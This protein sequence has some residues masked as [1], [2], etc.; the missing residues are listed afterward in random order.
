TLFDILNGAGFISGEGNVGQIA[1]DGDMVRGVFGDLSDSSLVTLL[2]SSL[3]VPMIENSEGDL[4]LIITVPDDIDWSNEITALGEVFAEVVDSGATINDVTEGDPAVL[5]NTLSAINVNTILSSEL[6]TTALINVLSQP[7]ILS[8]DF[9]VIPDNVTWRDTY[10][11]L[12]NLVSEGE[13]RH[14]LVAIQ[15]LSGVLA[16]FDLTNLGLDFVSGLTDDV[17]NDLFDSQV[18]VATVSDLLLSGSLPLDIPDSV[19]DSNG[20]ITK[21][22]I[23]NLSLAVKLIVQTTDGTTDL[24]ITKLFNLSDTDIDTLLS[25]EI[26]NVT[27]GKMVSEMAG[28]PLVVPSTVLANISVNQGT[29]VDV[30]TKDEIKAVI[31][32]LQA[33]GITSFDN[34]AFDASILSSL[35]VVPAAAEPTLDDNLINQLLGSEIVHATVSKMVL[36]LSS[37][38]SSVLS[39]PAEDAS[40]Q[41]IVYTSGGVD[42]LSK[43]EIGSVLKALYRIGIDNFES[44]NFEDTSLFLDNKDILLDSA[45]IHATISGMILDVASSSVVIPSEDVLSNPVIIAYSDVTYIDKTELSHFFD[46]LSLL[47]ITDPTA[48]SSGLDLSVLATDANQNTFLS[49]A[50]MHATV[51]K[52]LF[53]L[54]SGVL[55]VPAFKEDGTTPIKV[56][57]GPVSSE[58]TFVVKDE[59]KALLN[60]F[61]AMGFTNLE[62]FGTS[63]SSTLL[64]DYREEMLLSSSLQ[65]TISNQL[66]NVSSGTLLIPDK[67]SASTPLRIVLTDVEY[68]TLDEINAIIDALELLGLTDLATFDLS[69]A[70]IFAVDFNELLASATMQATVSDYLLT[71]ALDESAPAGSGSLIIPSVFR[72]TYDINGLVANGTW[73]EKTELINLLTSLNALNITDF[74]GSMDASIVT[75]MDDAQLNVLLASASMHI[76]IDNMLKGNNNISASIPD[77]AYT[78]AYTINNVVTKDE[79]KAFIIASNTLSSSSDFT[80]VNFDVT[81]ITSL[82]AGDRDIVLN[83][84]IVRNI[85]TDQLETTMTADDPFDLYWPADTLYM[86]NDNTTFLTKDGINEVLTHYGLI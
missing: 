51:S 34:L 69:P 70:T 32:S 4:S 35:E 61:I 53:D 58:T 72:E 73:V 49:S 24:D 62:S 19:L 40:N 11:G 55:V 5:L 9:L 44:I 12:G 31:L 74:S 81:A 6:I 23:T 85:L 13:L 26:I 33:L 68:V 47:G 64:F 57:T 16:D 20:Y 17:I 30:V 48:F 56:V 14:I 86:N 80:N 82:S 59:I 79:I 71:S 36:D 22:E 7:E 60:A 65:A 8:I 46:A 42:L 29:M 45:I 63:I 66:L 10:D 15:S 39:V 28:D 38:A 21:T 18:L 27:I 37:G 52:T 67:D 1:V 75:D 50:I 78:T 43:T 77:L 3:L 76:T 25:S 84:M 54:G 83:S 41:P 2:V